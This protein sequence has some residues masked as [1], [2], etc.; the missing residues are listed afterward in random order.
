[1]PLSRPTRYV[2]GRRN[3]NLERVLHPGRKQVF[4][5]IENG[6]MVRDV[7]GRFGERLAGEPLLEPVMLQGTPV[8]E[9]KLEESRRRFQYE[10][11]RLPGRLR[12]LEVS[13]APYSVTF[14]ECLNRDLHRICAELLLAREL[15][16][17]RIGGSA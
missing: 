7:I 10:I 3:R 12:A 1:M 2:P 9:V 6:R 5:Q 8:S 15:Q 13:T 16:S 4:R 14:S 11:A 17:S